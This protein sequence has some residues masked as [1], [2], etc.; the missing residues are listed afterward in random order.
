MFIC[1]EPDSIDPPMARHVTA[2]SLTLTWTAPDRPNGVITQY[3][4]YRNSSPI[5]NVCDT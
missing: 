2:R 3:N 1:S 4:I 5:A